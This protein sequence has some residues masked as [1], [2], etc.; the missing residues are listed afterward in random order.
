MRPVR[1]VRR[2]FA[3]SEPHV[4]AYTFVARRYINTAIM[5]QIAD[6]TE[7]L[8]EIRQFGCGA[9]QAVNGTVS[10]AHA[11]DRTA[12]RYFV[13]G[14]ERVRSNRRISIHHVGHGRA[15]TNVFCV[16]RAKS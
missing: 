8:L 16:D 3:G 13:E 10:G 11:D 1:R 9:T 2:T 5:E 4:A 14:G 7:P 15:Q 12:L 6:E